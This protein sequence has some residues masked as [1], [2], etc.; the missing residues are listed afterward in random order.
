MEKNTLTNK[1]K[2]EANNKKSEVN[3]NIIVRL[4]LN[5]DNTKSEIKIENSLGFKL[6]KPVFENLLKVERL[7][8]EIDDK[9]STKSKKN[10]QK[11]DEGEH[12][13]NIN[14]FMSE[15]K[16]K[17]K[18][19]TT[20]EENSFIEDKDEKEKILESNF[21]FKKNVY[22]NNYNP[23]FSTSEKNLLTKKEKLKKHET[24]TLK[25]T[26]SEDNSSIKNISKQDIARKLNMQERIK[27][28]IFPPDKNNLS[29]EN[30]SENSSEVSN[31]AEKIKV[32]SKKQENLYQDL[33]IVKETLAQKVTKFEKIQKQEN[34]I[35]N[36][37]NLDRNENPNTIKPFFKNKLE[38]ICKLKANAQNDMMKNPKNTLD[39]NIIVQKAHSSK[40]NNDVKNN[41]EITII[42]SASPKINDL[43]AN[44]KNESLKSETNNKSTLD[45]NERSFNF[46]DIKKMWNN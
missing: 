17:L 41:D 33:D 38:S 7:M 30:F 5:N 6:E 14:K 29:S 27:K 9:T 35:K 39:A 28:F 4:G 16:E 24:Y 43:I 12:V 22:E 44:F 26:I 25:S 42:K 2:N 1:S 18:I 23:D 3:E 13:N 37:L 11:V 15:M 21:L 10:I 36:D 19:S 20:D 45:I 32:F 34:D 31:V 46:S 40:P 8:D